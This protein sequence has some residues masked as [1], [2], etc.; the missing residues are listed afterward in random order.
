W[1]VNA[2]VLALAALVAFGGKLGDRI[3]RVTTFRVGVLIFF[4]ASAACGLAPD[5]TVLIAARVAQGGG[6]ALMWPAS[7]A[8][9][10]STF[11]LGERGRAM[12]MYAGI[13]QVFLAAGP[14]LGGLLTEWVTWRAVFWLNVPVG[15]AA[16][17]MVRVAHPDNAAQPT[18]RI[19]V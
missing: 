5:A 17:V 4:V 1:V 9:M 18:S 10:V 3:G 13:S 19:S 2:Y 8:I 16:L 14:L 11:D 12:A 6:A 7:A 15:I